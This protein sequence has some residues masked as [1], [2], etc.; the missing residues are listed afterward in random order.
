MVPRQIVA[1]A[2]RAARGQD[3]DLQTFLR[4]CIE[5]RLNQIEAT[6]RLWGTGR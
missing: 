1:R 3:L 5:G 4:R 6:K 2:K